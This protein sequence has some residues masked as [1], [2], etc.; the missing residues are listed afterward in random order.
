MDCIFCKIVDGT[1]PSNTVY[2]DELV[3]VFLDINPNTN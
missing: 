1:I 3:K 2:E